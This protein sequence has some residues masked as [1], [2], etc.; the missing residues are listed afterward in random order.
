MKRTLTNKHGIR[1]QVGQ[2]DARMQYRTGLMNQARQWPVPV[3]AFFHFLL[4]IRRRRNATVL[5]RV[6]HWKSPAKLD[7]KDES[8]SWGTRC[9]AKQAGQWVATQSGDVG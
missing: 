2:R 9:P 6:Q 5:R 8:R 4:H 1:H 3:N 7:L